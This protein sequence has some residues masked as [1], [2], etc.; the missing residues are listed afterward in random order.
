MS[1]S[2]RHIFFDLDRT[3]WNFEEN[4]KLVLQA[5][6]QKFDL[7]KQI[8]NESD[9][10]QKYYYYNDFLWE[11]Y[12][13]NS[14]TKEQLRDE[15]FKL[16]LEHFHITNT[17]I[18][19]EMGDF[20]V[21]ESPK[22]TAL[23]PFAREILDY[24]DGKYKMHIIT[25]GFEEVQHIKLNE[26]NI[27]H[28]FEHLIF[29]EKVGVKKP[30]PLIFKRALKYSG[31]KVTESLMIGDD[32]QADIYGAQRIKMDSVY[33]NFHKTPHTNTVDT[34]ISCLSELMRIL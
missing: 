18:A 11:R 3:L 21:S 8:E 34:E 25:N 15:R 33:Y 20:Y 23:M 7:D 10:I 26:S 1:K 32:Y 6:F 17:K 28:Y 16:T 14:I 30:H 22:Q 31:A 5:I 2:Y 13:N 27:R 9:F 4:S 12:R 29:S 24:L 19:F